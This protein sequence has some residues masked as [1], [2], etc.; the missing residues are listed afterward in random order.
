MR[1]DAVAAVS[2]LI[3]V[4]LAAIGS[5]RGD[6]EHATRQFLIVCAIILVAAA[7][8]F[9]VIVPRIER[10]GRGALILAVIGAISIVVFWLGIPPVLAGGATLLALEARQRVVETGMATAALVLAAITVAAAAVI[11]FVG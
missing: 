11:A 10:L 1:R 8:V 7:V 9:W 6:D 4:A 3:A 2:A 5:F